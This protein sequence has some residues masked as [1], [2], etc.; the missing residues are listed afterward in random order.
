MNEQCSECRFYHRLKHNFEL[1]KGFEESHCCTVW[2][3]LEPILD[4]WV[5]EITADDICELFTR[6]EQTYERL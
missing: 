6:K 4:S 1:G 5:Q 3:E 2:I